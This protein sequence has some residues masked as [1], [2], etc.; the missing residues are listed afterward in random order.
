MSAPRRELSAAL[1]RGI[2]LCRRGDWVEGLRHLGRVA[3][4]HERASL[5]GLFYS[6]LGYGI[7]RCEQR[8]SE[9]LKLCEH[10]IKIEFYQPDNYLNLARTQ[11]L[12]GDRRA[13]AQAVR[14]GLAIDRNHV[15][16]LALSREMG[17]RKPPVLPFLSRTNLLNRIL[18][19]L[20]HQLTTTK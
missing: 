2:D 18:G 1:E 19:H 10:S 8:I 12:A 6:Y 11:L 15:E 17:T 14:K 16:L 5:P 4:S 20:R 7:A 9:G 13:A 3:E